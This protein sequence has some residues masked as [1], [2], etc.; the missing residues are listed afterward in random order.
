MNEHQNHS[1]QDDSEDDSNGLEE[2]VDV[3]GG[4]DVGMEEDVV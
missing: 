3:G 2:A 1:M 4:S